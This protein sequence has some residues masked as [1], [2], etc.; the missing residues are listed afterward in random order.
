MLKG[1]ARR[2]PLLVLLMLLLPSSQADEALQVFTGTLGKMPI[3]L[4][5]DSRDPGELTGRYFY[6]KYRRD[7]RLSGRLEGQTLSLDEGQNP[8]GDNSPRPRLTL[9]K[10]ADG[11][12]GQWRSPKGK[13][14][15]VE[16]VVAQAEAPKA[17]APEYLAQLYQG[18]V[19]EYLRLQGLAL[20]QGKQERFM[21][22][23]LQWW[24]EPGSK[25]SMF[26]LV[27]GYTPAEQQRINQQLLGRFWYEVASFHGCMLRASRLGLGEYFQTVKPQFM[28]A[29]VISL[30]ITTSYFCGG[31][32]PDFGDSPLNI[33]VR[34]G[35][36]LSLSD[37]L[38]VGEGRPTLHADRNN[39]GDPPSTEEQSHASYEYRSK[40]LVPWLIARWREL[41]P[42][43]MQ[44]PAADDEDSCNFTDESVWGY[45]S[46][47][48]TPKG[49]YLGS[50]FA[51]VQRS[52]DGA[53]WS[54]LPYA[55]VRQHPGAV[56]LQLPE[57]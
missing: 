44:T 55:L 13:T 2:V 39:P 34:S 45:S 26:T 31:A 9:Q 48:F 56:A 23:T 5:L 20:T 52:C 21:G 57:D 11:W 19:Y 15:P 12:Q 25:L 49:L 41:Y 36:Q 46:W 10:T 35:E 3:V 54:V 47:Y 7:L 37:V 1:L 51:R 14:L 43:Q 42:E 30:N 38:W 27:S 6:Q 33:D 29:G 4:E 8:Y 17:D 24:T 32:H 28:S 50:Y 16:L 22:R 18:D 53:D 40:V